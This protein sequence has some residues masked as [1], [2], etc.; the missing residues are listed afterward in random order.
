MSES[1]IHVHQYG[2][3]EDYVIKNFVIAT[4]LYQSD[5][6]CHMT[7]TLRML[8]TGMSINM[9]LVMENK[10]ENDDY[11]QQLFKYLWH[12]ALIMFIGRNLTNAII[13]SL[14]ISTVV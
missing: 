11:I 13:V 12:I 5:Y 3:Q 7:F 2:Q 10:S 1:S 9:W 14:S 6:P 4:G 8:I